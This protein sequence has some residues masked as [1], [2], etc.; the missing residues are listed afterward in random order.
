[1]TADQAG[2]GISGAWFLAVLLVLGGC[3]APAPEPPPP[4]VVLAVRADAATSAAE[5]IYAGEVRARHESALAFRVGGKLAAREVEVGDR[6]RKGQVLAR[7]DSDDLRLQAQAAQARLTAAEAELARSRGDRDR[8]AA[9]AVQKWVSRSALAAQTA[10]HAAADGQAR[11][12][13]ADFDV[14]RNQARY[15]QLHAPA[16]GVISSREVEAGQVVSPGQ[17]VF[18]LAADGPREIAIALPESAIGAFTVGQPAQ[19]E[20]WSAP[21]RRLAGRIRELAPAAD[22]RSRTYAARVTL[23]DTQAGAVALGQSA[24]V[25]FEHAGQ[26]LRVPSTAVRAGT[27]GKPVVWV[28]DPRT[29]AARPVPIRIGQYGQDS[30]PVLA[31]L[32][33]DALV[34]AAGA[35]LLREGEVVAPVDRDNRPLLP[36]AAGR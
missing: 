34:V 31:G 27:D 25:H 10:A 11:S 24:R 15:A 32:A 33:P 19:V 1:M 26:G 5:T 29:R 17:V 3:R 20:L 35:H 6:V 14:A 22:P 23:P 13:R 21:G 18:T 2:F 7:L 16:A 4:R 36:A 12:A 30:V 9:L 28:V 8:Y